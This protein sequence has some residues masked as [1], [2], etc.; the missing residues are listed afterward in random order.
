ML[1]FLIACLI[2]SVL[3]VIMDRLSGPAS[4][5]NAKYVLLLRDTCRVLFI[6]DSIAELRTHA[7]ACFFFAIERNERCTSVQQARARALRLHG[8]TASDSEPQ[9]KQAYEEAL[10]RRA[11]STTPFFHHQTQTW[12]VSIIE[13]S[14]SVCSA[15]FCVYACISFVVAVAMIYLIKNKK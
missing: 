2:R 4:A 1:V 3:A 5:T 10:G 13:D 8:R 7:I 15:Q 9:G 6:S 11:I 12:L 14:R